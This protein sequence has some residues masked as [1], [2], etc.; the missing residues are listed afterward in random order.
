ME[1]DVEI[2]PSQTDQQFLQPSKS[3]GIK[4]TF[5]IQK[6]NRDGVDMRQVSLFYLLVLSKASLMTWKPS[7]LSSQALTSA[8]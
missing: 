6:R 7:E 8:A 5:L 4:E 3:A 2:S 1:A